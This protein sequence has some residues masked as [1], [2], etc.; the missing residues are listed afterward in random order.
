[1]AQRTSNR[2]RA[3]AFLVVSIAAAAGAGWVIW[4]L[5]QNLDAEVTAASAPK[6]TVNVVR[7]KQTVYPGQTLNAD[8]LEVVEIPADYAADESVFHDVTELIGRVPGERIVAQET[9]RT[10]RLAAKDAGVGL[11]AIIPKDLR[12]L[13]LNVTNASAVSGFLNPGNFVDV[14]T[15]LPDPKSDVELA[16]ALLQARK[17]LAVDNRMGSDDGIAANIEASQPSVTLAVTPEEAE[18]L[19]HVTNMSEVM[20]TLRNDIDV[21]PA[22]NKPIDAKDL[23]GQIDK[24]AAPIT[25]PTRRLA[26]SQ[27]PKPKEQGEITIIRGSAQS[28]ERVDDNGNTHLR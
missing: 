23:I 9:I 6:Q 27:L 21:E 2:A 3:L 10:E 17:I 26:L 20:L 25:K 24:P 5:F 18:K 7:A 8:M 28:T 13:S 4:I 15:A 1:M 19:A 11:N 12:A 14:L 16:F 22:I